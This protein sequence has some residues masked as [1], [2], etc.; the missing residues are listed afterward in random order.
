M[1]S[2]ALRRLIEAVPTLLIA[3]L[4]VF[5]MVRSIPGDT[6]LVIAGENASSATLANIRKSLGLDRPLAV[7]YG[8]Y[9]TG[10]MRGDLGTSIRTRRPVAA[11][12]SSRIVPSFALAVTTVFVLAVGGT[13]LGIL[14]AVQ[15]GRWPDQLIRVGSVLGISTPEFAVGALSIVLFAVH[16]RVLPVGGFGGWKTF[17]LPT[18]AG[19]LF[20]IALVARLVRANLIDVLSQDF[21][22]TAK[23]KGVSSWR[24]VYRH[25]LRNASIPAVTL[26]GL[27]FG[28]SLGGLVVIETVF[29][30]PGLGKL[31]IDSIANRDYPIVQSLILLFAVALILINLAVDLLV[32]LLDPRIRY[33]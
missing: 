31:L 9:L 5:V 28:R 26:I 8:L 6:A 17:V 30:W 19:S 33:A 15:A 32:G 7:Q 1:I 20:G 23:A 27:E 13:I 29:A 25:A 22:R 14:S 16:W 24:R 3:T 21:V 12:L 2:Y 10:L 18:L 4:L 11:E